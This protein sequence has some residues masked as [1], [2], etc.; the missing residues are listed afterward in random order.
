MRREL[1][2]LA[3]LILVCLCGPRDPGRQRHAVADDGRAAV[4]FTRKIE[5]AMVE[6]E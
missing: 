1:F 5:K 3:G 4:A 2:T 6:L